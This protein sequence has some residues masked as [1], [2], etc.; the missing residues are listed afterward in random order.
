MKRSDRIKLMAATLRTANVFRTTGTNYYGQEV[1]WPYP[2]SDKE[3]VD[4]AFSMDK[5][6]DEHITEENKTGGPK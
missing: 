1:G 3:A 5:Y 6:I 4:L 2:M